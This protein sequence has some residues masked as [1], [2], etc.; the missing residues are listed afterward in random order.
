LERGE[1]GSVQAIP[2][3]LQQSLAARLDRLGPAREVA[4]IGAVLGRDFAYRLLR[5]VAKLD[6]PALQMSLD[7]L[8][9]ADLLYVE[10]APPQASYR[11]KHALIQ[12]AAYDS[13]LKTRRQAL[14]RRAAEIL[15]DQPERA[16]AEPEVIAH[17]FTQVGL[18]D[19]AIEWWGK[20]GDQALRRSAFH[21]AIAHLGK[22][23]AMA[24]KPS[25]AA[26][27]RAA[28]STT[29]GSQRLKLQTGLGQAMQYSLGWASD[30][31][32]TAFARARNL[33]AGVDNASERFDAY[34]GLF[35][36]SL[37]RGELSLARETA[38]SLLRDAEDEGRMT[39]A[40]AAH[41]CVGI[42]RLWQG[43]LI[44]ARTSFAEALRIYD[45]ERDRDARF[46]FGM[47]TAA[48]AAGYLALASWVLGDIERAQALSEEALARAD[49]TGHA[50]TRAQVYFFISRYQVL[51]GD[52]QAA[53]RA[54]T[55]VVDLSREHGMPV[56]LAVGEVQSNWARFQLGDREV[57]VSGLRR[58]LATYVGQGNKLFL[59]LFQGWLAQLEAE[60]DDADGAL[61]RIDEAMALAN[62]IGERWTDSMLHRIRGG[63]L[64]KRDPANAAP[65]EEALLAA[66]AIAQAQKARSFR[67][68]S[69]AVS[70]KALSIDRP[71][72]RRPRHPRARA[73]RLFANACDAGDCRGAGTACG[74][75]A[76]R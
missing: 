67:T 18:D 15:R 72:C 50:P 4:Q 2:P 20:A 55:I 70:R 48:V 25:A 29:M 21:E 13:L 9:E 66:V 56:Y 19:L 43:D 12:D 33:A 34:F 16:A 68:P 65:A 61:C 45:S 37:M 74:A 40:A 73:R 62:E 23:I 60:G 30:E 3:T 41:R 47:D 28:A 58:A 44:S 14:H 8:A 26:T 5:D 31:S 27:P 75:G 71:P 17:H 10:G 53:L 52:P 1:Q 57:G 22:A 51:R 69:G 46:R 42:P 59:P 11:F 6:E 24:D 49:E 76:D 38:E 64:L 63:I 39:E 36:A 32:K 54:A 7:R 35:A